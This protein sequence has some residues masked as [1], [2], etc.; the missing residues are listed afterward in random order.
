MVKL[1]NVL[2][3]MSCAEPLEENCNNFDGFYK[4]ELLKTYSNFSWI[5]SESNTSEVLY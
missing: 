3:Y 2:K 5:S 1:K 4:S